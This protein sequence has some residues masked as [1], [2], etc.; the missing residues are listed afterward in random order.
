MI[1]P[2]STVVL[3]MRA[4]QI[5]L[6][7]RRPNRPRPIYLFFHENLWMDWKTELSPVIQSITQDVKPLNLASQPFAQKGRQRSRGILIKKGINFHTSIGHRILYSQE[8]Y[9]CISWD[10]V[11]PSEPLWSTMHTTF[12]EFKGCRAAATISTRQQNSSASNCSPMPALASAVSEKLKLQYYK[13][14]WFSGTCCQ[15]WTWRFVVEK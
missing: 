1:T 14:H 11:P 8:L 5:L 13:T 12:V 4:F 3:D 15:V 9:F 2:F 6:K 10:V 7:N